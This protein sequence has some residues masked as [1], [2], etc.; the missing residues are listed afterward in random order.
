MTQ[1]VYD[2]SKKASL[3]TSIS[4]N[5]DG[6]RDAAS[7]QI[8]HIA[9]HS[10]TELDVECD[11]QTTS[12]CRYWKHFA[13][14]T[15]LSVVSTYTCSTMRPKLH[16]SICCRYVLQA[17]SQ[18]IHNKSNRWSFSLSAATTSVYRRGVSV[19]NRG[20]PSTV[21]LMAS[22]KTVGLVCYGRARRLSSL[23][24]SRNT[25]QK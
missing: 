13:T 16:G 25:L 12:V 2:D 9:L 10:V 21:L 1:L 5:A 17:N 24:S 7:R 14:Q 4:A 11:H 18:Q 20:P 3:P 22:L 6:S 8:D 23:P 19:I 15:K